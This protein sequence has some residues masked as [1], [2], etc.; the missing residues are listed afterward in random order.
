MIIALDPTKM[1]AG[2]NFD[3]RL[4]AEKL[5]N[6]ILSQ[7]GAR[8][9]STGRHDGVHRYEVRKQTEAEGFTIPNDL[10]EEIQNLCQHA[11]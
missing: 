1:G 9:P 6:E 11:A 2:E 5:F 8:L 4:H 10:Y 7:E 3:F